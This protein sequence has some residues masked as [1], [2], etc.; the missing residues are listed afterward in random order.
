MWKLPVGVDDGAGLE[1]Y[2]GSELPATA[3]PGAILDTGAGFA[4]H[5][6]N[7]PNSGIG[8]DFG[9]DCDGDANVD[10]SGGRRG[11]NRDNGLGINH[12]DRDSTCV[13]PVN[14]QI[15]VPNGIYTVTVDFGED[16][17]M[18]TSDAMTHGCEVEGSI[19]CP[20][21]GEC[22]YENTVCVTDGFFTVTGHG[23]AAA[24]CHSISKVRLAQA[25]PPPPEHLEFYFGIE[26]PEKAGE[27]AIL[28]DGFGFSHHDE[29]GLDYGWDCDGDVNVNY[30]GGRRHTTRDHGLGINHL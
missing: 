18:G 2:F 8:L 11:L 26:M 30:E 6:E 14:W 17:E 12:F 23:F 20:N 29:S 19:V 9:W 16:S 24:N 4:H 5:S 3:G 15:A 1:F 7:A 10:Y 25:A 13:G 28:A 27:N 22:I 21:S